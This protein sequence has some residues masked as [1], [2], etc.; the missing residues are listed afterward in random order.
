MGDQAKAE[1]ASIASAAPS[2]ADNAAERVFEAASVEM[3]RLRQRIDSEKT[4]A[5][6][7]TSGAIYRWMINSSIQVARTG[8]T[9][10]KLNAKQEPILGS[11]IQKLEKIQVN[12]IQ[13]NSS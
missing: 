1:A 11:C 12:Q 13:V 8:L 2:E 4:L 3:D 7:Q 5:A 6:S 10:T 9:V